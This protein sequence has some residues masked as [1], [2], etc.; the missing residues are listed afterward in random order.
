MF[1][2]ASEPMFWG[3][4]RDVSVPIEIKDYPALNFFT[5]NK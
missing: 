2:V 4:G 1:G 3:G 5:K